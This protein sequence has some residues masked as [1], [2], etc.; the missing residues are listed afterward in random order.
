MATLALIEGAGAKIDGS[1]WMHFT[2]DARTVV[3]D[4]R[5]ERVVQRPNV[6]EVIENT[7]RQGNPWRFR[8]T[9]DTRDENVR[10]V[11][12]EITIE[13]LRIAIKSDQTLIIAAELAV[14]GVLIEV[15]ATI[16]FDSDVRH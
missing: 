15:E 8:G 13:K 6:R 10:G 12:R 7:G 2:R 5:I 1:P 4:D 11:R 9:L 16:S 14:H 3:E